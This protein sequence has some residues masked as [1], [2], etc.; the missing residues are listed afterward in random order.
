M[1]RRPSR[2]PD[3]STQVSKALGAAR[4]WDD[5]AIR[6]RNGDDG[7]QMTTLANT[8]A[9]VT[10]DEGEVD[11]AR[12][13]EALGLQGATVWMTGLPAAGKS[14]IAAV[15]E[16]Q[17]VESGR[18]A[19]RLDGDNLRHGICG[20]LGFTREHRMENVW[21]VGQVARLFADAGAIAL[22]SLVSPYAGCRDRVR[23]LHERDGLTFI[24]VF[25]DT[26]PLVCESR[27]P[28]GLYAKAQAGE[29]N[30]LTGVDDPYEPPSDPQLV[31]KP[32]LGVDEAAGAVLQALQT[33][34][35]QPQLR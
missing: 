21:R 2:T 25:V 1:A 29:L 16:R 15:V 34:L 18:L 35:R 32:S 20:D 24:E 26:P 23:D 22:V 4:P 14:T 28:K 3:D 5:T 7:A 30:G 10:W 12:R 17:L 11:R 13:W 19:Y 33:H 8:S 9:N 6:P 31:L 27:D